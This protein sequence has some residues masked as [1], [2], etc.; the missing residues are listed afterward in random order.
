MSLQ[1]LALEAAAGSTLTPLVHSPT[2]SPS[3]FYFYFPPTPTFLSLFLSPAVSASLSLASA[4]GLAPAMTTQ[5]RECLDL[6]ARLLRDDDENHGSTLTGTLLGA[7]PSGK[8]F[9]EMVLRESPF[10]KTFLRAQE[11]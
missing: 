6:V 9:A 2:F 1:E 4:S 3:L 5:K 10:W 7:I 8:H 11:I